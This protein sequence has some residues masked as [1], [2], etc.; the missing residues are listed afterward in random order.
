MEREATLLGCDPKCAPRSLGLAG[1]EPGTGN[2]QRLLYV[3]GV[4]HRERLETAGAGGFQR[5][6]RRRRYPPRWELWAWGAGVDR[7]EQRDCGGW[8][9]GTPMRALS[10]LSHSGSHQ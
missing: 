2:E 5:R 7:W 3:V 8:V 1:A 4:D 6:G 9:S 10:T